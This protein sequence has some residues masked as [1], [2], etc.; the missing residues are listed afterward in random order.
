MNACQKILENKD[1]IYV[2]AGLAYAALEFWLG[3]TNKVQAASAV[4]AALNLF[5]KPKSPEDKPNG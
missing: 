3:K 1:A 2:C 4:E 5:V